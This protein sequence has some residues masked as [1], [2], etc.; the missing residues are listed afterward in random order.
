[1][2][3]VLL[4]LAGDSASG[5]STL[6]RGIEYI[7][8][9]ERVG[10]VCTDDYHRYDRATRAELGVT[11]L[12][13][14]SNRVDLMESHLRALAEGTAV[15]KPTYDHRTGTFGPQETIPSAEIVIIE[16]LLPLAGRAA[17]EAIDVAVY[18]EPEEMLRRRWKLQ[19]DVFERDYS[20][21]QVVD[22]IRR[23]EPDAAEHIRPQRDLADIIVAFHRRREARDDEHLSARLIVRPTLPYAGLRESVGSLGR[24]GGGRAMTKAIRWSTRTDRRGPLS[25]LDIDGNCPPDLGEELEDVIWSYVRPDD[26][27]RWERIGLVRHPE[28]GEERSEALAL[29]QL[30]IV[31]YLVGVLDGALNL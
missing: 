27:M 20:P 7:V 3:P 10:R 19:R 30:L 28:R 17:R 29:S 12:V 23:R 16:G 26:R 21:Q 14:E 25:V 1:M 18:L 15:T 24:G 5:K 8:G 4:A 6:A 2:R 31:S 11:P 9:M 22:E 13:P